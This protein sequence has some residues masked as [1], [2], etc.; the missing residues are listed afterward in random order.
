MTNEAVQIDLT[1]H[2]RQPKVQYYFGLPAI[3]DREST[4]EAFAANPGR[5]HAGDENQ[6]PGCVFTI[7]AGQNERL[8]RYLGARV[9]R[10]SDF[11][12]PGP[13]E[14]LI[15]PAFGDGLPVNMQ[16]ACSPVLFNPI[17]PTSCTSGTARSAV[18]RGESTTNRAR[19]T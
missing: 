9:F 2:D 8:L 4:L 6:G 13:P 1:V 17:S 10:C 15:A 19:T 14:Y 11:E 16:L 7:T 3:E 18:R 12:E 5:F